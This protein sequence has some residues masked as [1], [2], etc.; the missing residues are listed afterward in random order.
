MCGWFHDSFLLNDW[1]ITCSCIICTC[2]LHVACRRNNCT[3]LLQNKTKMKMHHELVGFSCLARDRKCVSEWESCVV[4]THQLPT[5][6]GTYIHSNS[7]LTH[8]HKLTKVARYN[9]VSLSTCQIVSVMCSTVRGTFTHANCWRYKL[10]ATG[11]I[12]GGPACHSD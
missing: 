7:P 10:G 3:S 9:S 1:S 11:T 8:S 12:T 6:S 4:G 5:S 2:L